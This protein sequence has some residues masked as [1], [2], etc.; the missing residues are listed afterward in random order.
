MLQKMLLFLG[1]AGSL[2]L[3]SCQE[4]IT[5]EVPPYENKLAVF[6]VL[7]PDSIPRLFLS[8]SK[9]YFDYT[10][11]SEE[12]LYIKNAEVI[13]KDITSGIIDTLKSDSGFILNDNGGRYYAY[14][15]TGKYAAKIGHRYTLDIRHNGKHV[16]S[17]TFVPKPVEITKVD[18]KVDSMS[19]NFDFYIKDPADESN[20]YNL[21][22]IFT[23]TFWDGQQMRTIKNKY[24]ENNF[25][26]DK[27]KNGGEMA[28]NYYRDD[29]IRKQL[30]TSRT[31]YFYIENN[32]TQ[33]AE[34][35][36]SVWGQIYNGQD[37]FF[38][39]PS[40][41]KHNITGGLGIFGATTPAPEYKV[42]IK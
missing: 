1:L 35:L 33:T 6:C 4:D 9:S 10:D 31:L 26:Y 40:I 13:I 28:V 5:L 16:T 21:V 14:F 3:T 17:E 22:N 34:Y 29:D 25:Y 38:T 23:Y 39:E 12:Y 15:Y 32:T 37:N 2:L 20:G 8:R 19:S 11:K 24:R 27:L 42:V 7:Q 36:Q 41:V 18:Y 30:D